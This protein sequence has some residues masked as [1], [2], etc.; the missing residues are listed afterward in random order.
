MG[1][2]A[3]M[4][5]KKNAYIVLVRINEGKRPLGKHGL[6]WE[7]NINM[8]LREISWEGIMM[9]FPVRTRGGLLLTRERILGFYTTW[10]FF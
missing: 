3:R 4:G 7:G 6:R 10:E 8:Y 2:V 1:N 5:Q 9:Y